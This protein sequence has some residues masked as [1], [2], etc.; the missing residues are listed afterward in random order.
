ME[1]I[2]TE[3]QLP[4]IVCIIIVSFKLRVVI[5]GVGIK[6]ELR[7]VG[8]ISLFSVFV[9]ILGSTISGLNDFTQ[10][11]FPIVRLIV[12]RRKP[13]CHSLIKFS[14][15]FPVDSLATQVAVIFVPLYRSWALEKRSLAMESLSLSSDSLTSILQT[16]N[17][18]SAFYDFLTGE[19]SVGQ[20]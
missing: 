6:S 17:G 10:N 5:E 15:R 9:W 1:G 14:H 3:F 12:T 11:T 20:S 8:L 13:Q 19:F 4:H 2:S 16:E 7:T 18:F